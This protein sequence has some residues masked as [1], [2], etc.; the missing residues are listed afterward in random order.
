[1]K[2]ILSFF[3]FGC[4]LTADAAVINP[5]KAHFII[6]SGTP[7]QEMRNL[8]VGNNTYEL[9]N[10]PNVSAQ[11]RLSGG[12]SE[13]VHSLP[14]GKYKT[15]G[16]NET[17]HKVSR[18]MATLPAS[19]GAATG[20]NE[21]FEGCTAPEWLPTGWERQSISGE[22][23]SSGLSTTWHVTGEIGLFRPT[24]GSY[25]AFVE[26][27][28]TQQNEWL[29]SPE[30]TP[31]T[32]TRLYADVTLSLF[33]IYDVA[34]YDTQANEF[35]KRK[36]TATVAV[37]IFHDGAW[38]EVWNARDIASRMSDKELYEEHADPERQ[39]LR[40]PLDSYVGKNIKV[41][42]VY[43][44][45]GGNS[46]AVDYISVG[47]PNNLAIYHRP[48]G[49]FF[50]G[51]NEE[52]MAD[53]DYAALIGPAYT[54]A[55]WNLMYTRDVQ[56]VEWKFENPENTQ[57]S[58]STSEW[59]PALTYPYCIT[60]APSVIA[61][62]NG[63]SSVSY[64]YDIANK[65]EG[66]VKYGGG[67]VDM[68][69]TSIEYGC[70]TYN[71]RCGFQGPMY[72]SKDGAFLFGPTSNS[73]FWEPAGMHLLSIAS[74]YEQPLAPYWF[75]KFWI[76]ANELDADPDAE[77]VLNLY[78]IDER[79]MVEQTPF[80]TST[81]KA[82]NALK[83]NSGNGYLY[84]LVF[85]FDETIIDHMMLV[86]LSGYI[87]NPKVRK[88][89]PLTQNNPHV[90]A[91]SNGYV[92]YTKNGKLALSSTASLLSDFHCPFIF[93][94]NATYSFLLA[95]SNKWDAPADGGEYIFN[96]NAC[97]LTS[98]WEIVGDIPEW[99]HTFETFENID[100]D[101]YAHMGLKVGVDPLVKDSRQW[102]FTLRIPGASE[103]FSITQGD[104]AGVESICTDAEENIIY[105]LWGRVVTGTIDRLRPG[106][107]LIKESNGKIH[108]I[109]RQ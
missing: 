52:Y 101:G 37:R 89:S 51:M 43:Y 99:V 35:S 20:I 12:L 31:N 54:D 56:S 23:E 57:E 103:N 30:F 74:I 95:E 8:N 3:L 39:T 18:T 17:L 28:D 58:I 36:V 10:Q 50:E 90:D 80:S 55:R 7:P 108:K 78:R 92:F 33:S 40:L 32:G 70:G 82:E 4:V 67:G 13:Y 1:M 68:N 14:A 94:M 2:Y 44:G 49:F 47:T 98:T 73:E 61:K 87:D 100:A 42:F 71:W 11:K 81:L 62:S 48:Q 96:I 77:F 5:S 22:G 106:I 27:S 6:P 63:L 64:T 105:D 84:S 93:T 15:Y 85:N 107:Y 26:F 75:D 19:R 72:A 29:I 83:F 41:A 34:Y 86:E 109:I 104:C 38:E 79:G 53:P 9:S 60:Y 91:E 25:Q 66:I 69:D 16:N 65:A 102:N 45:A 24:Q 46:A 76:L 21:S 88:F 59:A 97:Y